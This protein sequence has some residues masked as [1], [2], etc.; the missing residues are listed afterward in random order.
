MNE[1]LETHARGLFR[2][3]FVDFGPVKA[4]MAGNAPYRAPDLWSLFP[5]SLDPDGLPEGW[6]IRTASDLFD[7]RIGRT[8]PRKEAE[9]FLDG[10]S[11][12]PWLSIKT[13][14]VADP[15]IFDT[16]E[17]LTEVATKAFR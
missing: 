13:M 15:F 6:K 16:E 17:S 3:R 2:D 12:V 4:K 7:I 11:G 8:P 14:G 1:T 9:H 5:D 10:R